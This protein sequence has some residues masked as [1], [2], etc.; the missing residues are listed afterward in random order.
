MFFLL[1]VLGLRHVIRA[2]ELPYI[3]VTCSNPYSLASLAYE[4]QQMQT[5]SN[6]YNWTKVS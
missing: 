6:L 4:M 3:Q 2:F 1:S 5:A